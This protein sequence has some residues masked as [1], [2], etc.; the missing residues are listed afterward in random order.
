MLKMKTR[1]S[2]GLGG[3]KILQVLR[4]LRL[5][6]RGRRDRCGNLALWRQSVA[7]D[8]TAERGD[9]L[10]R[11]SILVQVSFSSWC[12]SPHS[13]IP[14]ERSRKPLHTRNTIDLHRTYPI[15][16]ESPIRSKR[17][18]RKHGISQTPPN[19]KELCNMSYEALTLCSSVKLRL[20]A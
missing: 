4:Y 10:S 12:L 14:R 9:L 11:R 16:K 6:S 18:R 20:P 7:A 3:L 17:R 19:T 5:D 15:G 13:V 1:K 2:Q 8:L